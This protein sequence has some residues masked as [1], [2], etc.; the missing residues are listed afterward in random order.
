[1]SGQDPNADKNS[2]QLLWVI[3]LIFFSCI[4]IWYFFGYWLKFGFIQLKLAEARLIALLGVDMVE[5]IELLEYIVP[6]DLNAKYAAYIAGEV[7]FYLMIPAVG[8]VLLFCL[9]LS[10]G[11]IVMRYKKVYDMHTLAEQEAENWPM[12]SPV[13]KLDLIKQDIHKGPWAMGLNPMQFCKQYKLITVERAEDRSAK[14]KQSGTFTA[15]VN[16]EKAYRVFATQLGPQWEGVG[17]LPKYTRALFAI[18]AARMNH[19]S[20]A[21]RDLIKQLAWT[22]AKGE[23]DYTG[24]TALLKKHIKSRS[25]QRVTR[26]HGYVMTVMAT[27]ITLARTDGVQASSDFLW[28]KPIDRRLWY[29]LNNVGRQTAWVEVSGAIAHWLAELELGRALYVPMIDE[30]VKALVHSISQT[31]YVPEEEEYA[32]LMGEEEAKPEETES[33]ESEDLALGED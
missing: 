19:D 24:T 26:N 17:K 28:L 4:A 29:M 23:I 15:K 9:I 31:I 8:F 20:D 27:M 3:G 30:A 18:F 12:I 16:E 14:F 2:M 6:E 1:M 5:V 22:A 33:A 10:K 25:V 13:L 7:G 21:A 11:H 32:V